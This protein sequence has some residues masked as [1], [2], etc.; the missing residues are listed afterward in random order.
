MQ[1]IAELPFVGGHVALD[2]VN[3][4]EERGHPQAEDCLNS[5]ADLRLWGERYGL[6]ATATATAAAGDAD[7]DADADEFERAITARE[8]LYALFLEY[9]RGEQP[10]EA[11]LA[12][13]AQLAAA[14][15]EAGSLSVDDGR[16]AWQWS[17]TDLASVRHTVVAHAVELLG[18]VP[19][20]RL[21]QCPGDHCGWLFLDTTKRGNRRWCSMRECGQE[22]KD[23]QRRARRHAGAGTRRSD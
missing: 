1:S 8:L 21:K 12:E 15:H 23:A 9:T 3:T 10:S 6:L 4:A 7:A 18:D 20:A 14:A 16:V 11:Q 13:L 5:P 2:F 19:A 22:A 17:E